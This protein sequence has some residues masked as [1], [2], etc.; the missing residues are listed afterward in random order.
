MEVVKSVLGEDVQ[1]RSSACDS[2]SSN[3]VNKHSG[4]KQDNSFHNAPLE[5]FL[6]AGALL[7]EGDNCLNTILIQML[8]HT[9]NS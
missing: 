1:T 7:F 5:E 6:A 8:A 4:I 2:C 9:L 3:K